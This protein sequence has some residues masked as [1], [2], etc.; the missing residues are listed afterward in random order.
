MTVVFLSVLQC[1]TTIAFFKQQP[2]INA[3]D[4]KKEKKLVASP[5]MHTVY[6]SRHT[7]T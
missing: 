1:I 5:P 7:K 3:V 2:K 6:R 4:I